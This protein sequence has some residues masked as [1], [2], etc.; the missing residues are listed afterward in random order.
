MAVVAEENEFSRMKDYRKLRAG[1]KSDAV[2]RE[3]IWPSTSVGMKRNADEKVRLDAVKA[4][5]A[6]A[7][8]DEKAAK[9]K[10]KEK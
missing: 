3:E 6:A 8:A 4:E 1:G 7:K 5:D 9:A 2:A 10:S